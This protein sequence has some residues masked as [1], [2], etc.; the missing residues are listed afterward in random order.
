MDSANTV[1]C[2]PLLLN[3]AEQ[4]IWCS[5]R[6]VWPPLTGRWGSSRKIV[7]VVTFQQ[8]LTW[9]FEQRGTKG[10]CKSFGSVPS[11]W[12]IRKLLFERISYL[13]FAFVFANKI[14]VLPIQ[15]AT[16][17]ELSACI[18]PQWYWLTKRKE[19]DEYMNTFSWINTKIT[20]CALCC[21]IEME[22]DVAVYYSLL[23]N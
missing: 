18:C 21:N 2:C 6:A 4:S 14:L 20:Y 22:M 17:A 1:S 3:C 12:R 15:G 13:E 10:M 23:M 16:V 19:C 11:G 8:C 7:R 9:A 5:H